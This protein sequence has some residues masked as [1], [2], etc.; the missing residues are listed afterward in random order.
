[1]VI[2]IK[3]FTLVHV[4]VYPKFAILLFIVSSEAK[5]FSLFRDFLFYI[6]DKKVTVSSLPFISSHEFNDGLNGKHKRSQITLRRRYI[7]NGSILVSPKTILDS[8]TISEYDL[9]FTNLFRCVI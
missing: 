3:H 2:S 8:I 7:L 1:M 5:T 6:V 9:T 4:L